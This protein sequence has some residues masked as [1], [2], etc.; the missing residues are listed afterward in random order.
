MKSTQ[1]IAIGLTYN[2]IYRKQEKLNKNINPIQM[3]MAQKIIDFFLFRFSSQKKI[4]F[5]F[6]YS[7]IFIFFQFLMIQNL[8]KYHLYS[9][10]VIHN[11]HFKEH[12]ILLFWLNIHQ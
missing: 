8:L 5:H 10:N 2:I 7:I 12:F 11:I 6:T 4:N 9:L 1:P 3:P